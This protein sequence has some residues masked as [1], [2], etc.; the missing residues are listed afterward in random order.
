MGTDMV[1]NRREFDVQPIA[2]PQAP[3]H[4]SHSHILQVAWRRKSLVALGAVAGVIVGA[5]YY[6]QC[7]PVY[8]S[9]AQI[10]VVKKH[11]DAVT[12]DAFRASHFDDYITTHRILIQSPLIVER[13]IK[14]GKLDTLECLAGTSDSL[15]DAIIR[16]LT[17]SRVSRD[18]T[19]NA[20]SVL[21]LSFRGTVPHECGLVVSAILDSYKGF[22]DETYR[23]MS[24]DTVKLI[25][26]AR[27]VVESDM[28]KKEAEYRAF[29]EK[30]PMIWKGKDEVNPRQERLAQIESQRSALLLRRADLEGQLNTLE[31]ARKAGRSQEEL[32]AMISD[33]SSKAEELKTD[34]FSS[35]T[36]KSQL[37]PLLQ[38]ERTLTENYGPNHP[39]VVA[40]RRR[41]EATRTFFAL[42]SAAYG[43]ALD[44]SGKEKALSSANLVEMYLRYLVQEI[45][46]TKTSEESLSRLFESEHAAASK[47]NTYEIQ[48]TEYRNAIARKQSLYDGLV[49]RLQEASMVKDYGGFEARIIAAPAMGKKVFPSATTIFPIS[50]LLGTLVGLGLVYLAE[51]T[52]KS[53]RTPEEIRRRLGLAVMGHIPVLVVDHARRRMA[54]RLGTLDPM[55]LTHHRPRSPGA[56]AY[57]VVRTA[58][59]FSSGSEGHKVIQITSPTGGDGKSTLTANVA[60]S[61]AQS[62]KRTLLID[63]DLRKPRQHTIFGVSAE[64]GLASV[65]AHEAE[66]VDAIQETKVSGLWLLPCGPLPPDPADLLTSPR[67][68]ELLDLLRCQYDYVLID[69][70]PV[71]A[72]TDACVVAPRV[73]GVLLLVRISKNGGP[74]AVRA[75]E[76]LSTVGAK[77]LGVVVNAVDA[78]TSG[79]FSYGYGEGYG[80]GDASADGYLNDTDEC[81]DENVEVDDA[82]KQH[83]TATSS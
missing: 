14:Q 30:S 7:T 32:V 37:L 10:L 77:T 75:K 76:I 79:N 4:A 13:A 74:L 83:Q 55:L 15:S 40:V 6:A 42:P 57:R 5:L 47:M 66:L 67:L 43:P 44:K 19:E 36:L 31:A 82:A 54:A 78:A 52:D 62:G 46:R 8:R 33:L 80:Y 51:V 16:R 61:I 64:V 38:E 18:S 48:D 69:T 29:R 72:V 63:A 22:L 70:A 41:I 20:N 58:L 34:R 50:G 23:D 9:E 12:G 1:L 49:K 26:E 27:Q 21:S 59:Y 71:L 25:T 56:E 68:P 3:I 35:T 53:F 65:I 17:V 39:Q 2:R 11:P 73:D 28:A 81:S 24:E 60:V 45:S